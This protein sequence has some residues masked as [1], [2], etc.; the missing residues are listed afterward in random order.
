MSDWEGEEFEPAKGVAAISVQAWSDEETPQNTA[1]R[2]GGGEDVNCVRMKIPSS[3]DRDVVISFLD[4]LDLR[5]FTTMASVRELRDYLLTAFNELVTSERD[6]LLL[7]DRGEREKLSRLNR[8]ST[9]KSKRVL[10]EINKM[11]NQSE[12]GQSQVKNMFRQ[13]HDMRV[14][15]QPQLNDNFDEFMVPRSRPSRERQRSS[16]WRGS[17][18]TSS[19]ET[20]KIRQI[21]D[22]Y[23]ASIALY[24]ANE[25]TVIRNELS[26]EDET[27]AEEAGAVAAATAAEPF[28]ATLSAEKFPHW[29]SENFMQMHTI[30]LVNMGVTK[31]L[32]CRRAWPDDGHALPPAWRD[33]RQPRLLGFSFLAES[34]ELPAVEHGMGYT[35]IPAGSLANNVAR[36][37]QSQNRDTTDIAY[38]SRY[39][40]CEQDDGAR[41]AL[42]STPITPNID[43][44]LAFHPTSSSL[45]PDEENTPMMTGSGSAR[46]LPAEV[47]LVDVDSGNQQSM[48]MSPAAEDVVSTVARSRPGVTPFRPLLPVIDE[49]RRFSMLPRLLKKSFDPPPDS[50]ATTE[51]V[52]LEA[53]A[54]CPPEV[55]AGGPLEAIA[56]DTT[57]AAV[58]VGTAPITPP[59]TPRRDWSSI[60][61]ARDQIPSYVETRNV[62][63]PRNRR[64][65]CQ[66][67]PETPPRDRL[68]EQPRL[69]HEITTNF[70]ANLLQRA[71]EMVRA[72]LHSSSTGSPTAPNSD[73]VRPQMEVLE[74]PMQAEPPLQPAISR[75]A[76]NAEAADFPPPLLE[77]SMPEILPNISENEITNMDVTDA[78]QVA[79]P[80]QIT[81][82]NRQQANYLADLSVNAIVT[83]VQILPPWNMDTGSLALPAID[84]TRE[85]AGLPAIE[86]A[87]KSA[88]NLAMY[89]AGRSTEF[90]AMGHAE[91][92]AVQSAENAVVSVSSLQRT[93]TTAVRRNRQHMEDMAYIAQHTDMLRVMVDHQKY[94]TD[95]QHPGEAIRPSFGLSQQYRALAAVETYDP[96]IILNMP[97]S[98]VELVHGLLEALI[99][100]PRVDLQNAPFIKNRINAARAFRFLLDLQ[101]TGIVKLSDKG[102]FCCLL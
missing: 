83:D 1:R 25:E 23:M 63:A 7:R 79:V 33:D 12:A 29:L 32:H 11:L 77:P 60:F 44:G 49:E 9:A 30:R 67:L 28:L 53:I 37:Q 90:P 100:L 14:N 42:S 16:R 18:T 92:S 43:Y 6:A 50:V 80:L 5:A 88:E 2:G 59:H 93:E 55:S 71:T 101:A 56:E 58:A 85:S 52:S 98:K 72:P 96:H 40:S 31:E 78:R 84:Q 94:L 74:E 91:G 10:A 38:F 97:I 27:E 89:Q 76:L 15:E 86:Q 81:N 26:S 3:C 19:E 4:N 66:R 20:E 48:V 82:E 54:G 87:G 24:S 68:D 36:E 69:H 45:Q 73:G 95:Q 61:R 34:S 21:K 62:L 70:M 17:V 65:R 46:S 99:M 35:S 47:A 41:I 102:R 39:G 8:E 75:F 57:G 13:L 51:A 22:L 64:P